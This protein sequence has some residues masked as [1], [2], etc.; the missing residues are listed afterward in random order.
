MLAQRL[1]SELVCGS[2][3]RRGRSVASRECA[4]QRAMAQV[5]VNEQLAIHSI[6]YGE[7]RDA[8]TASSFAASFAAPAVSFRNP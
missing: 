4:V 3:S 5:G 1:E 2:S 7:V 6:L 8:A